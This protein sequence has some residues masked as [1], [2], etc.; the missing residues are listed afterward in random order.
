MRVNPDLSLAPGLAVEW[1]PN[2]DSTV[3][4]F[5]LRPDVVWHDGKPF[6]AADVI[7]TLQG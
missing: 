3:W 1:E 5:K 6:T 2:A 4:Q 7:Y